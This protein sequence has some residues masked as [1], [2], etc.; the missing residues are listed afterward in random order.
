MTFLRTSDYDYVLP[1][2]MIAQTPIEPRD[3]SRLL[4]L[5]RADSSL[6][7]KQFFNLPEY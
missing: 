3:H 2:E 1:Q 4:V 5:N 6:T 7:H